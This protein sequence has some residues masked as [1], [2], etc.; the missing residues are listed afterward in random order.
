M[1][2]VIRVFIIYV[3]IIAG[4][5]VMGKREFSQLTPLELIT[6]LLIPEIVAQA[7]VGEDFSLVNA[8]IGV[9]TL[10]ALVFL[11][12]LLT[13]HIKPFEQVISSS[14]KLLVQH[15]QFIED[16]MNKERITPR[17]IYTE[18]HK[19]GLYELKQARWV[20]LEADGKM[21]VIPEEQQGE[22]QSSSQDSD[23]LA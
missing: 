2:T 5:R 11:T 18:L 6:L 13:Q 8:I 7:L 14:P 16:H 15:G 3:L 12:S 17:E 1:E 4:L 9:A 22:I 10:F 20:I 21:A 19:A 23:S